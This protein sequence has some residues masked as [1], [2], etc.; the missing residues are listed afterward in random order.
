MTEVKRFAAKVSLGVCLFFLRFD[1]PL[2]S[3]QL[4]DSDRGSQQDTMPENSPEPVGFFN[5]RTPTMGGQQFWTD[6]QFRAGW[7][8]QHNVVTGHF[9]LIDTNNVRHAWGNELHCQQ[10]LESIAIEQELPANQERVIVLLHGLIRTHN[11]MRALKSYLEKN[12]SATVVDF[13]YASTRGRTADQAAALQK[14]IDN[15]G[16]QITKIDFVAHSLGNIVVRHYLH[17]LAQQHKIPST[18]DDAPILQPSRIPFGRMV[19]LAP[20][21]QGSRMASLMNN[22]LLFNS[23]VGPTGIEL[24]KGWSILEKSLATPDFEFAIIAGGQENERIIDNWL[25]AGP[26]D[27][28]V[29]V[30]ETKLEGAKEFETIPVSHSFI[31]SNQAVFKQVVNFL[32]K[33][34]LNAATILSSNDDESLLRR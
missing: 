13:E 29:G 18:A 14:F 10:A 24:G 2:C 4:P 6:V 15:L 33:G 25:L 26:N 30:E 32:D 5:W 31:I 19:M 28:T 16:D 21:N 20:P 23:V 27:F 17:D 22:S 12:T 34:T 8:I 9:R 3:N 1:Q 7:K 11:S